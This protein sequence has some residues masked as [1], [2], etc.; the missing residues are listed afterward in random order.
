[1][2]FQLNLSCSRIRSR[3]VFK[4]TLKIMTMRFG[5]NLIH[6]PLMSSVRD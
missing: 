6:D 1:M 4:R 2:C 3:V 5:L